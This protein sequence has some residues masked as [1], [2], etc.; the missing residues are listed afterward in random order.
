MVLGCDL[1]KR[2]F[3]WFYFSVFSLVVA[4][5]IKNIHQMLQSMCSN[6]LKNLE[7]PQQHSVAHRIFNSILGV[8]K[9]E[10]TRSVLSKILRLCN[11]HLWPHL[12]LIRGVPWSLTFHYQ[13]LNSRLLLFQNYFRDFWNVF[14][15]IIVI[16][17]LVGVILELNVSKF[18]HSSSFF[19]LFIT[20]FIHRFIHTFIHSLIDWNVILSLTWTN[21]YS[22]VLY[23]KAKEEKKL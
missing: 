21:K 17:T 13:R 3:L 23:F 1:N 4:D 20:F 16:T 15:F 9:C 5:M 19:L 12:N 6:V 2:L 11:S 18:Q 10:K 7:V 14:D 22:R 8:W